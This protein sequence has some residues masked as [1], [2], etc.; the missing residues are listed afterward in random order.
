MKTLYLVLA[1]LSL[2]VGRMVAG[3]P[4][5]ASINGDDNADGGIDLSDAVYVLAHLFQGGP[6]PLDF[7][8]GVGPKED[9]CAILN[10]D[11]NGDGSRDLSDAIYSLAFSFQGGLPPVMSCADA[12]GPEVCNDDFDND[13]DGDTDCDDEDCAQ[14]DLCL[15]ERACSDNID[16]DGDG[17]TDCADC[18][19]ATDPN[20]RQVVLLPDTGQT[21]CYTA[22]GAMTDCATGDCPGQDGFYAI[23]CPPAGRFV[24]NLDG[25]VT[26]TCTELT[27]QQ[28]TADVNGD[29]VRDGDGDSIAWCDALD[30]SEALNFAGKDDWRLPNASE[31]Q[32]IIDYGTSN[33]AMD[34]LFT[35]VHGP[36]YWASTS[37][38]N[39]GIAV[40]ARS[41]DGV[42]ELLPKNFTNL[43]R[44]VRGQGLLPETG[45]TLCYDFPGAEIDCEGAICPGQ[46]GF[47][48]TGCSPGDRFVRFVDNLDGT[49]TDPGTGLTWQQDAA[50]VSG[51]GVTDV[52][53]ILSWCPSVDY[54]DALNFAGKDDWRLPNIREL[55]SI[56][57]YGRFFPSIDPLFN[58][59]T[60]GAYWSSTTNFSNWTQ[61]WLVQGGNGHLQRNTKEFEINLRAV[62]GP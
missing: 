36:F 53:D 2:G 50:D 5:C 32:S 54:C 60:G 26:D 61:A 44:A 48:A 13:G 21:F 22:A 59:A 9:G 42:F 41:P 40:A 24:D 56:T 52:G 28:D 3:P 37:T 58:P 62:R 17:D 12:G 51:D 1:V 43:V 7:C 23:G 38:D 33:P 57:D 55:N 34:P 16:S 35:A 46:D 6:P 31:L 39:S 15:P 27:W 47:Y 14:D 49:V 19:C 4:P 18:D 8:F 10:G 45:Q 11:V 30:Y 29:G 20:C 25:T